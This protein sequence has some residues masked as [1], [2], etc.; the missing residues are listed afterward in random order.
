MVNLFYS[1]IIVQNQNALTV[2]TVETQTE[3]SKICG[4]TLREMWVLKVINR[5]CPK[6]VSFRYFKTS[7]IIKN[8]S[9]KKLTDFRLSL[10]SGMFLSF[11]T[12][13]AT[14]IHEVIS[15]W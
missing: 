5:M 10:I 4:K 12:C 3:T 14:Q 13:I 11:E 6:P 9:I 2:S 8:Y 7:E 1:K 15:G